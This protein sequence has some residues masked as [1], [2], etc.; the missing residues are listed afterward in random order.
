MLVDP[1][2]PPV[3]AAV[4]VGDEVLEHLPSIAH[5]RKLDLGALLPVLAALPVEWAHAQRYSKHED[6]ARD[7]M[8]G[9]DEEDWPTVAL[10]LSLTRTGSVA[11]WTQDKDFAVSGLPVI[12]TGELLDRLAAGH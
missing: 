3:I 1:H 2:A 8:R 10:A 5:K 6:E 4:A 12:T 7:V 11:I 9:R